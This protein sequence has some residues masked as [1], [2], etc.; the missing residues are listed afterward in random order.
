[1]DQVVSSGME[2]K[3]GSAMKIDRHENKPVR[4]FNKEVEEVQWNLKYL[5]ATS[6]LE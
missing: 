1:M 3:G 2:K 6:T 4:N 5:W